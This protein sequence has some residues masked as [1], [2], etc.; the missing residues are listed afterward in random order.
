MAN[1]S[2][3]YER[4]LP[5]DSLIEHQ[6]SRNDYVDVF[7]IRVQTEEPLGV[8]DLPPLFFEV[9]P[10]WFQ[11]LM[12]IRERLA[13]LIGLKTAEGVDVAKQLEEFKGEPGQSIALFHVK[14]R[15]E[16]E[17][18]TGEEDSHLDFCL[19]FFAIPKEKE[20]EII[21]ATTVQFNAW[22]GR[23]YFIP[24]KPFHRLIVPVVLR[25]MA[26]RLCA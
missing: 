10:T 4:D 12:Y 18:L 23:L 5:S 16:R 21:L 7:A 22:L 25:R 19:S 1:Y 11:V 2:K 17:I 6:L 8:D 9:F 15:S 14:D 24:V 26:K 3:A 20:T 13:K